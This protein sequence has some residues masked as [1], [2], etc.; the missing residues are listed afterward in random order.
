[1]PVNSTHPEY[2]YFE[3]IWRTIDDFVLGEKQVKDK[4]TLYLPKQN[5]WTNDQY[6]EYLEMAP[7]TNFT[8]RTINALLGAMFI[9]DPLISLPEPITYLLDNADG[10]GN[11]I[12]QVVRRM[13][14]EAIKKGRSGVYV[15]FPRVQADSGEREP[16]I[17]DTEGLNST[18]VMYDA[19]D[20]INWKEDDN[21]LTQVV[22]RERV[23]S[24]YDTF[25]SRYVTQYRVL[26]KIDGVYSVQLWRNGD[27]AA[28]GDLLDE[29]TPTDAN[30]Q[31]FSYIPFFFNGAVNNDATCDNSPVYEIVSKNKTHY[32]L[33]A[34]VMR[35]IITVGSPMLVVSVGDLPAQQFLE[36]NG[37]ENGEPLVY[38]VNRGLIVGNTG[39]ASLLQAKAND[40]AQTKADRVL[41]EAIMLGARL[42]TKGGSSRTTAEQI[43][44]ET[45]AENAVIN[46][47]AKNIEQT[48]KHALGTVM[49]FETGQESNDGVQFQ[50]NT[51]FYA[52]S[53]D[54]QVLA[55]AKHMLDTGLM[56]PADM[57]DLLKNSGLLDSNRTLEDVQREADEYMQSR[58]E[59]Q[60]D[61]NPNSALQM[62]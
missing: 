43:R 17:A 58:P 39:S 26:N 30:K 42:V 51:E 7:F 52:Q 20:I 47:I 23:E 22:L 28:T 9:K 41:T 33:E 13:A 59:A 62:A 12:L 45:S 55:F 50:M 56:A 44:I 25:Q 18:F 27:F 11:S 10:R 53:P 2:Q 5:E 34:Q 19:I 37:I 29:Y 60:I 16:S 49:A 57:L 8:V 46:S 6:L 35:S 40:M 31:P 4:N 38:G 3:P 14:L 36:L 32:Q 15:D 48:V 61:T 21:G 1:M 24:Q 54:P